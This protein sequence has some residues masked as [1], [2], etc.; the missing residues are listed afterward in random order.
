MLG[1]EGR[2][3]ALRSKAIR[4]NRRERCACAHGVVR[5]AHLR[6]D[7]QQPRVRYHGYP[8][9]P[10]RFSHVASN[11]G[12]VVVLGWTNL[13]KGEECPGNSYLLRLVLLRGISEHSDNT[14]EVHGPGIHTLHSKQCVTDGVVEGVRNADSI[15]KAPRLVAFL[16][17]DEQSSAA[18]MASPTGSIRQP[19]WLCGWYAIKPLTFRI[20]NPKD[21]ETA[22]GDR[23]PIGV[24]R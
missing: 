10:A 18:A 24:A 8:P 6:S 19:V 13:H 16:T 20:N 11:P 4:R 21:A 15:S 23:A 22:Q 3:E 12:E 2:W 1:G 5:L 7:P 9:R 17:I 14:G